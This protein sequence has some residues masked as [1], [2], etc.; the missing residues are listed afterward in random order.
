M[1]DDL[2]ELLKPTR[3][4]VCSSLRKASRAVTNH[5]EAAFRG[6][7]L[8]ATQFTVL[9]N[10][11]QTGPMPISKLADWLGLERTTLTRNL[12]HLAKRGLVFETGDED[13]RVRRAALTPAGEAVVRETFP[14]WRAAQEGVGR[15]LERHGLERHGLK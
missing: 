14:L 10:L 5:Y 15:V 11:A 12:A 2:T 7:G 1:S 13:G 8:R 6:S 3:S 9:S 4:C